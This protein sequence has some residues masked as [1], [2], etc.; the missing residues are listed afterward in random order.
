MTTLS[1]ETPPS[2]PA[3]PS[4]PSRSARRRRRVTARTG[5]FAVLLTSLTIVA[6]SAVPYLM[7]SLEQLDPDR[8]PLAPAYAQTPTVVQVALVVHIVG[9]AVALFVGPFQFWAASRRRFPG[10]HRWLGRTY[11]AGVWVGGVASLVMAPYNT[12]GMIGFLGFGTLG[13]LWVWT[14]WRAYR[15][16]RT[17]D[18]RS[19]Q[20][21]MIRNF[22][23]TFGAVM[24]RTWTGTLVAAQAFAAGDAFDFDA[25]FENAYD[26]VTFLAWVPNLVIAEWMVRRRGLPTLRIVDPVARAAQSDERR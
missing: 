9:A 16:I 17:G 6:Y 12:A 19:H 15:A 4:R 24:L 8:A 21:W 25:A 18:V 5:W 3:R 2:P 10:L 13:A 11:L 26:A 1:T 14:G 7:G 23:L 20:A 22:S